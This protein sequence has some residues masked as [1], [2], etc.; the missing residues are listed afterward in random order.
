MA[1][2]RAGPNLHRNGSDG[3]LLTPFRS[4]G[5]FNNGVMYP[6][7]TR[8]GR[9]LPKKKQARCGACLST[10]S[11]LYFTPFLSSWKCAAL[12]FVPPVNV[13]SV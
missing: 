9:G 10:R 13:G 8:L 11:S 1:Q 3:D 5:V 7:L 12:I 4:S 6:T 2:Q